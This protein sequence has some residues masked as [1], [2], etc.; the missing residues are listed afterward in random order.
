[1]GDDAVGIILAGGRSERLAGLPVG[2][3]GKATLAYGGEPLL[4][5][6][7][8][9]VAVVV[10]RVIVVAAHGQPLPP[11]AAGVE[12]IRDSTAAAGPLAA[13]RDGLEQAGRHARPPR[14][15][16]VGSC[17]VPL[18]APAVVRLLL[19]IA[20]SCTP[21]FVVPMVGGH[22]QVLTAVVACDLLAESAALA[23][24]GGSPRR[25]LAEIVAREPER[26][27]FV[28]AE[29]IARVDAG[30]DSFADVDTPEDLARLES[31]GF[32]PSRG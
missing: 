3:G 16:F 19:D 11:L 26:V 24:L 27:R 30:L 10:P 25:L 28:T 32:P 2:P 1:M 14:W 20:R 8:R 21:R 17:D 7:C 13:L 15:A 29:E 12:V 22:P 6:V 5:R 31:R 18:L 23:A 4:S 9:A